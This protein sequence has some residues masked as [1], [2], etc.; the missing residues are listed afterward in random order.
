MSL[1]SKLTTIGW[2]KKDNDEV[3]LQ[4]S[5]LV[6][7]SGLMSKIKLRPVRYLRWCPISTD[8]TKLPTPINTW[9]C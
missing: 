4:K 2:Q 1:F 7:F 6:A 8:K 5:L 9:I 3:K